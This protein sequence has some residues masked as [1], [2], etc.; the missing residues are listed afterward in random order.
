MVVKI[1]IIIKEI[2]VLEILRTKDEINVLFFICYTILN[3]QE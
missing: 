1:V 3:N 2:S